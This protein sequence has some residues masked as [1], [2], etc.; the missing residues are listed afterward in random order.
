MSIKT[1]DSLINNTIK[2]VS[3]VG[4]KAST[5]EIS[6]M[7]NVASG[8]LFVH[9]KNKEELIS[10]TYFSIKDELQNG[11]NKKINFDDTPEN[12]CKEVFVFMGNFYINRPRAFKFVMFTEQDPMFGNKSFAKSKEYDSAL[13]LFIKDLEKNNIIKKGSREQVFGAAWALLKYFIS[14]NIENKVKELSKIQI[15]MLWD[16]IKA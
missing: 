9:F 11:L 3:E 10:N 5:S 14:F 6:K 12:I 1:K 15:A 8:T 16:T 7:S 13:E 2:L 4:L